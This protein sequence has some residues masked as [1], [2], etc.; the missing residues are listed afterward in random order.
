MA[1]WIEFASIKQAVPLIRV[2]ERYHIDGLRRSGKDQWRGP[3]P[4]HGGEGQD[5][6]H[7]NTSRQW[8]HCF[9]CGAGGTVL[10]LV[11]AREGCGV[12]DAAEKL[13]AWWN[14]PVDSGRA[15]SSCREQATVT[16]KRNE[17][18]PLGFHLRGIDGGHAYL[19]GRGITRQT[20]V[21]FGIGFYAGPGLLSGRVVLPVHD[22]VG[23][24][25]AYCGR[26]VDGS[27][28]RYRF[29]AGF[30]KSQV[31]F[32]LHRAAAGGEET[33][34]VVEGFFDCLRVHQAGFRS[35]VGLMGSA[36]YDRQY[37]LLT[38][39]F[40]KIILMLD[41]DHAGRRASAAI[42]A[43]LA[44]CCAVRVIEVAADAQPDQ[45]SES[46]IQEMLAQEGGLS[47]SC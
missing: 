26:S 47:N 21:A 38:Q 33:V 8:F 7:V 23:R 27:E 25:L 37:W 4:L 13:V 40:R 22:E 30:A 12:R 36:L 41:G 28:P 29:P 19:T 24:L 32:N 17:L 6:F 1:N 9:A 5:A 3:C 39:R 11:S 43:R 20:A 44:C 45:L 10:D 46:A 18:R 35:V 15:S 14:V 16:K 2:L 34:V 42:A 31:L